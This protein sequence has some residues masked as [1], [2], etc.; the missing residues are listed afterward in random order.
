MEEIENDY[1]KD[2]DIMDELKTNPEAWID[3][4]RSWNGTYHFLKCGKC[5]GPMLG[6]NVEKCRERGRVYPGDV[7]KRYEA[8]KRRNREIR[9]VVLQYI[10]KMDELK[11]QRDHERTRSTPTQP[12]VLMG[13]TEIPKWI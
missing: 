13:K 2:E 7:V 6:H 4:D 9:D 11:R 1:K 12:S 10:E 5:M 3:F 8:D